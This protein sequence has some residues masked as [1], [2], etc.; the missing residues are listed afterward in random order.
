MSKEI[1]HAPGDKSI[2]L[3][4]ADASAIH[5]AVRDESG[6]GAIPHTLC[7]LSRLGISDAPRPKPGKIPHAARG[8]LAIG[9]TMHDQSWQPG[10]FQSR[11]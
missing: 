1:H 4:L 6:D 8:E 5:H 3:Q 9:H 7:A 10:Q 11:L 2:S